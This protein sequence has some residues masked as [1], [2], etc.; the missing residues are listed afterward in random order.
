MNQSDPTSATA[1]PHTEQAKIENRTSPP[2]H[3]LNRRAFLGSALTGLAAAAVA[4]CG[5]SATPSPLN[6]PA[7]NS[8]LATP[9]RSYLP[10]VANE[11]GLA[12][13]PT[14]TTEPTLTPT[15]A[16]TATPTPEPPT[17]TPEATPFPPGPP[18]KLG[19]F[20]GHND[21]ELFRLLATQAVT[22]VKTL[23]LD[24]NF[25]RQIKETSP[26]TKVIGRIDLPQID[27]STLDPLP[28]ARAFVDQVLV[29]ADDPARRPYIDGWEAYNEPVAAN[30]EEMAKL[31][32]FEAERTR[33]LGER[34]IRSVIG[35]FGTG[36]PPLEL[37]PAF[38]PA[39]QA[40]QQ[41]DGWLGLHEYSAPTIYYLS[42]RVN[43][44]RHPGVAPGDTG[45]LTLR[46]RKVYNDI[47]RPAGLALPLV[48]TEL[49]VDG[50]VAER[51]GPPD[52]MGWKDF[53]GYWAENG[54]GLWG[55]GAYIE[56]LVWYDNAMRQDDYVIGGTIYALAP[57]AG[58]ESYDIRGPASMVLEQ[59]LSVHTPS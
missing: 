54:Y 48:L 24:A 5:D 27:L 1:A 37:W 49:G 39:L 16:K 53:Q 30:A 45:W 36:Q 55:P 20:I 9:G 41:Y 6:T 22:V 58:W 57:T 42:T 3:R 13:T 26:N 46:Y 32:A 43:M 12:A 10:L 51:P 7:P 4:A 47:L 23:E 33:L 17:P 44:G 34:G 18:S 14:P 50:L 29:Y 35:N 31:A 2:P 40:A 38:F 21:P 25:L 8:P 28:A 19:L 59:Y 15:P 52:A 56:Q 11:A